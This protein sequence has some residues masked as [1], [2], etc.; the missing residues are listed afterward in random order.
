MRVLVT[1]ASGHIGSAVVPELLGAGH[2]V[3][4][5]AR[6]ETAAAAVRAMGAEVRRGDLEDLEGLREAAADADAVIHLAFDHH[7]MMLAGDFAGA[8]AVDLT[9]VRAFGDALAGTGRPAFIGIG[10]VREGDDPFSASPRAATGRVVVELA[11]RG[12]RSVLVAV[13]QVVHS[14]RDRQGFVP[15]LIAIARGTGV[16]GYVGEGANRWP[17]VHTLD[18]AHLYRLALE[19]ARADRNCTP[20]P[21]RASRSVTSPRSSAAT[22]ACPP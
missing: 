5:L 4:G 20:R 1:G 12:V 16:S 7:R 3:V 18:L 19:K 2:E 15:T 22:W 13:P 10:M 17:A 6:S 9:A 8:A 11:D 21:R 14:T